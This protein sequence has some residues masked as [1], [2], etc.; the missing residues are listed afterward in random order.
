MFGE[1]GE[2]GEAGDMGAGGDAALLALLLCISS[3]F[4]SGLLLA[5]L[6]SAAGETG[7]D[8][9]S[10]AGTGC[11][12][13]LRALTALRCGGGDFGG[14]GVE[15]TAPDSCRIFAALVAGFSLSV[16]GLVGPSGG[17]GDLTAPRSSASADPGRGL[18]AVGSAATADGLVGD[19]G[20][21]ALL[22][23]GSSAD[24][25]DDSIRSA[26]SAPFAGLLVSCCGCCSAA[27]LAGLTNGVG[28]R[29]VSGGK[30]LWGADKWVVLG[31]RL[32]AARRTRRHESALWGGRD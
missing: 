10:T 32:L 28:R 26:G 12:L 2:V 14:V 6:L 22:V 30:R 4:S 29:G 9:T 3:G 5:G 15:R 16:S 17:D 20:C 27:I 21:I 25:G 23:D 19:G 18:A 13:G 1:V 24:S 11:G 7:A 8:S 31:C